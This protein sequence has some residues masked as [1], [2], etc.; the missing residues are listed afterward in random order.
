MHTSSRGALVC[1]SLSMLLASLGTSIANVGLPALAHVFNASFH[2]VQWVVLAYLFAIT[3]VIVNA[4]RLGDRLGRRRLLLSGLLLFAAACALCA[5]APSLPWL[6]GARV[7]QGLGAAVMMAMTLAMVGETVSRERTG[8]VMGWLGTMSAVGTAMGPSVGGMLLSLW[9][10]RALFLVGAPLGMLAAALAFLYLPA[11]RQAPAATSGDGFWRPLKDPALRAGLA[12]SAL[13]S[14]VIMST[15]VVGPFYLSRGL[16][17]DAAWMG[18]AMAVG[19][20]VSAL[21][22]L[23]A[24]QLTDRLGSQRMTHAGLG[25]MGLGALLLA[26]ASGLIAYLGSLILLTLGYSLF[27]AANNTAV[28]NDVEPARRGTVSGLLNLSR[29]LGLIFGAW[30][31]GAVFAWASP[32]VTHAT[33]QTVA[34]G[35]HV[36]FGVALALIVTASTFAWRRNSAE[37]CPQNVR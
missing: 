21:N 36:T 35:L 33:A 15:F 17:L 16:G 3:A 22:G 34:N 8:R 2:A 10:W 30:A 5:V 12:M 31:L 1:L 14:A 37:N 24:G 4:G 19:P 26:V 20:C 13:V 18:L 9:G 23:P 32:D 7:L 6:I 27:Q 29:N 28:M 25:V 11:D